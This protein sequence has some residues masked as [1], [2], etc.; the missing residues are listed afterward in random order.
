MASS[1]RASRRPTSS[2]A[3]ADGRDRSR[4][5]TCTAA[6]TRPRLLPVRLLAGLHRPAERL[7]RAAGRLR[8]RRAR[9]STASPA[10][11]ACSQTGV[12]GEARDRRSSSSRTSSPRAPP[13]T[14]SA[15][16]TPA[17]SRSARS[18]SSAPTASCEWS[19]EAAVAQ[20]AAGR[21]PDLRRAR[22][23]GRL[24]ELG[25]APLP[26]VGPD[27]H[28]AGAGGRALVIV[29]ARLRVPVLRRAR[30]AAARARRCA[31]SSGTSRS[32]RA[33]RARWPAA[34]AAEAAAAAGRVLGDAR[35]AVRR[36]GPARGSA[37]VGARRAPGP[38]RRAL[39]RR[40]ALGARSRR[41][42]SGDFRAGVRA[43]VATT[44]TLFAGGVRYSGRPDAA[45]LEALANSG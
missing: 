36:P 37:P 45:I 34:C 18:C 32:A 35:R 40:P 7:Q 5:T 30:A 38:R 23:Q 28:V 19:Y 29:Y 3:R 8:R 15:S 4:A 26:P 17:A 41:A 21:Q 6:T 10:T 20:R 39:R 1:R 33:I 43:G 16:C 42:C 22:R 27:D 14:R 25:S 2:L 12:Q 31:W 9:R 44:P 24:S 13:A 11:R